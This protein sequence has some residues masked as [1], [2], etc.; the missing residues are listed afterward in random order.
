MSRRTF[1]TEFKRQAGLLVMYQ[2]IPIQTVAIKLGIN[3]DTLYRWILEYEKHGERAFPGKG[4][5]KFVR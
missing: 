1:T 4:I 2:G 5:H 3:T